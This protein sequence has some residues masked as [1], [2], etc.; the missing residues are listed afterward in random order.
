M[1]AYYDDPSIEITVFATKTGRLTKR[2][3]LADDGSL[4]VT[5]AAAMA[6]GSARRAA[7]ANVHEL[8]EVIE[9]LG[10]NEALALG[11]IRPDLPE[12]VK[13]VT[14]NKVDGAA[15]VIARTADAIVYRPGQPALALLDFDTKGMPADMSVTDFWA[16]LVEV[17]PALRDAA[18]V[19]RRSTSSGLR[20]TD[21]GKELPGSNGVHIYV[22]ARDG[23]DVERFLKTLHDRCWLAGFGWMMVG[24]AG[25]LLERSI[26]DRSVGAPERL[27]FEAAPLLKPPLAQAAERR[28]P[29]AF[30]GE[31]IDTVAACPPLKIVET[32]QLEELKAR[33]AH[34]LAAEAAKVRAEFITAQAKSLAERTGRSEETARRI[35]ERQCEGVLHPNVVLPFDDP[36]LTSCT[37]ADVLANPAGFEGETLA[38]PNEGVEYGR[39]KAKIMRR[40]D[41]TPWIHSFAHGRTIYELKFDAASVREAMEKAEKE[42][43]VE[44]FTKLAVD[45][46]LDPVGLAELRQQAKKLS[47]VGLRVIDSTL[48]AAQEKHVSKQA[49]EERRRHAAQRRDPRPYIPVPWPDAPWLPVMDVLNDV[50][51]KSDAAVPPMRDIDEV[52]TRTSKQPVPNTHA[53]T[54]GGANAKQEVGDSKLP[55]PEQWILRQMSDEEVAEMI[56]EHIDFYDEKDGPRRSVHLPMS[57]VRHYRQRHDDV[58]PTVAAIA[59]SPIVLADGVLLAPDGLDRDRG[60]VFYVPEKLREVVP[61]PENCTAE[62][63]RKAMQFLTEEWL[64]DVATDYVG[65]CTLIAA[66][67]TVIERS[68]LPDRPAFF[69]TAGRRG[70]GKTTTIIMLLM[71]VTGVRPAASSWSTNEEERRKALLAQFMCGVPYVLWDNIARGAQISCPHI[72]R[73]CTSAYYS[74]RKLG[75]SEMVSTA[76]SAIHFF[77]GNNVAPCGDL[78]SRSLHIRISV[79]RPDPENREF[80]HPDPIGW[81]DNNRAEILA[82]LYTILLGN[83]G[84]KDAHD[85]PAKTRFKMWWRL[86]GSAVEHAAKLAGPVEDKKPFELDFQYLFLK[87]EEDDEESAT[88][89]DILDTITRLLPEKFTAADLA[90]LVNDQFAIPDVIAMIEFLQPGAPSGYKFSPK[91]I[92]RR[93]RKHQDNPVTSGERTLVL[94]SWSPNAA[95]GH[96]YYVEVKGEVAALAKSSVE[97]SKPHAERAKPFIQRALE[98]QEAK[99]QAPPFKVLGRGPAGSRCTLCG[100]GGPM[101]IKHG[102]EVDLW[103]P[104]CAERYLAAM[105]SPRRAKQIRFR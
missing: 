8:V 17:L 56:E 94:R 41:G 3:E 59:T 6:S 102:R 92:G 63:V 54:S 91:S 69:V 95:E 72:E 39:C 93:L 32:A 9:G 36:K 53:F 49:Q 38:D 5:P 73:S 84:L 29:I 65:K 42:K 100:K 47:G 28:R 44:T 33:E 68:L 86:I 24:K 23:G 101:R 7:V 85:A 22:A 25:Q 61:E 52:A 4:A 21:T 58:L 50:I 30:E 40:T 60:I 14:K 37:V 81:T 74:D 83:P 80:K 55:A 62:A 76:A 67:M 71:A 104:E 78:A 103:H 70:G 16:T 13:V 90:E 96:S 66:A 2:I 19:V 34:R 18:H 27:V 35:I 48:K 46:D 45:A 77:S 98:K 1:Q 105:G 64:C 12:Q 87:Q 97:P 51:G 43:V 75:V 57:F 11:T 99:T 89:A 20:R 26:V 79:D 82:A 10:H 31:V 88:L 15:G